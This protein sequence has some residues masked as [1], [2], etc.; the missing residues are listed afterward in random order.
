MEEQYQ[1]HQI[2]TDAQKYWEENDSFAV[3]EDEAK[4]ST[5]ASPCSLTQVADCTWVTFVTTPS[6]M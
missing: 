6:V 5:T 2:E 3:T 1:P 4:R